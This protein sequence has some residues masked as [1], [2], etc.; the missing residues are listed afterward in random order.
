MKE[1]SVEEK[2]KA[3]DEAL[4]R[5]RVSRLQLIDIGEEATEIEHIFPEL[6]E[7]D[8]ERIRKAIKK[9]LQV[10]CDGSRIISDEPVTLEEATAWLEKQ[11]EQKP[12]IVPIFKVGDIIKNKKNG[13]TV[14]VEQILSDSYCYSGWDGAATIHS[15]FLISDQCNWELVE[16][17]PAENSAKISESSIEEKDMSEYNKGFEC[18]KQRV[19]KYPKDFGLCKNPTEWSEEDKK[20]FV[21]IKA[22]LRNANK[23]YSREVDW[24]KSIKPQ[25][26]QEW[27]REDEQYLLVCKNALAKYQ[28]SDKW[29]AN[30]ISRWLEN[31]LKSLRPQKQWKP[32]EEQIKAVEEALSLA[33]NCGEEY[34]FDLRKLLEQLKAL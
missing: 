14:K 30:I 16:Q 17:K 6:V 9:A 7:S 15:D 34:S 1:L 5:A 3:Y 11:G 12:N 28:I 13:G 24:L 8:D 25:P 4:E 27:S 22:C 33:K 18:G 10:R 31:R 20:M 2:A 29:D 19:L 32:T 21:N 23:D 26:K